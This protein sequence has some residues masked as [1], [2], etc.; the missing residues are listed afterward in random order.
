MRL[1]TIETMSPQVN[2]ILERTLGPGAIPPPPFVVWAHSPGLCDWVEGLGAYC[3]DSAELPKRLRLLSMLITGRH[4]DS[5]FMWMA[6]YEEGISEGLSTAS[7]DRLARHEDPHF[8]R[9]D[10][11]VFFEFARQTLEEH[12][13]SDDLYARAIGLFGEAGVTD[14]IGCIGSFSMS[15]L[16]LNVFQVELPA[17]WGQPFDDVIAPVARDSQPWMPHA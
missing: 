3:R 11:Q 4:F 15:A 8:E 17:E 1:S 12:R 7:L 16:M 14:A 9:E 6:H 10:E 13:V 5:P 2:D